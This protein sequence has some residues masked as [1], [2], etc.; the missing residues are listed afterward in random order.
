MNRLYTL[1]DTRMF[2]RRPRKPDAYD[3]LWTAFSHCLKMR[4]FDAAELLIPLLKEMR[5]ES[6]CQHSEYLASVEREEQLEAV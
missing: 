5:Y 1:A 2:L 4:D 3:H 6:D